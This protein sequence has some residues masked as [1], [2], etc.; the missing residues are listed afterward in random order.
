MKKS[1]ALS[2]ENQRALMAIY[3]S[4]LWSHDDKNIKNAWMLYSFDAWVSRNGGKVVPMTPTHVYMIRKAKQEQNSLTMRRLRDTLLAHDSPASM[5]R[6]LEAVADLSPN[7]TKVVSDVLS[8]LG[9]Q[10][11]ELVDGYVVVNGSRIAEL[12]RAYKQEVALKLMASRSLEKTYGYVRDLLKEPGY[13]SFVRAVL[14]KVISY[15]KA[16][17]DITPSLYKEKRGQKIGDSRMEPAALVSRIQRE[18]KDAESKKIS[19]KDQKDLLYRIVRWDYVGDEIRASSTIEISP[20]SS[21]KRVT[22]CKPVKKV[23][24]ILRAAKAEAKANASALKSIGKRKGRSTPVVKKGPKLSEIAKAREDK[25]RKSV[26]LTFDESMKVFEVKEKE[27][28]KQV[29]KGKK[30]ATKKQKGKKTVQE[31]DAAVVASMTKQKTVRKQN[32]EETDD[33]ENWN[34]K[35]TRSN[36]TLG[37]T[38]NYQRS[39]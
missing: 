24:P 20:I 30:A 26:A 25:K 6:L 7:M 34:V 22:E 8:K 23:S 9:E 14:D 1:L 13:S 33:D 15:C 3:V 35:S 17:E 10:T 4:G 29:A 36:D 11:F 2:L 39:P 38:V 5:S 18:L 19:K 31:T 37:N 21:F 16:S 27:A 32:A 28:K 12:R